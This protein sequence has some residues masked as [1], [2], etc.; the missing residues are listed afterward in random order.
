MHLLQSTMKIR[1]KRFIDESDIINEYD[2]DEEG[3]L[4]EFPVAIDVLPTDG[5][6]NVFVFWQNF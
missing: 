6:S 3:M 5:C 1:E 2:V 4:W